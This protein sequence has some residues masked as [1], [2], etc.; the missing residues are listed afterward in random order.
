[1]LFV[2]LQDSMASFFFSGDTDIRSISLTHLVGTRSPHA[3]A[4]KEGRRGSGRGGSGGDIL[5]CIKIMNIGALFL[6]KY[7]YFTKLKS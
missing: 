3:N 4:N 1:M 7:I 6:T 5:Q 2:T